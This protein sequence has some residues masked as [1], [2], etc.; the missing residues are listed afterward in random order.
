M[1]ILL[2]P[3]FWI[4][5][6]VM[7]FRFIIKGLDLSPTKTVF[8]LKCYC[9]LMMPLAIEA[10][11]RSM[12]YVSS[13]WS[14]QGEK[15]IFFFLI[16]SILILCF[17]IL[18]LNTKFATLITY[19]IYI[20]IALI[21]FVMVAAF[22]L[23]PFESLNDTFRNEFSEIAPIW[24]FV[25]AVLFGLT[26][27]SKF[28][29]LITPC[30]VM[31]F[32]LM[33]ISSSAFLAVGGLPYSSTNTSFV[34]FEASK[35]IISVWGCIAAALYGLSRCPIQYEKDSDEEVSDEEV[36]GSERQR[37]YNKMLLFSSI[38]G[39]WIVFLYFTQNSGLTTYEDYRKYYNEAL[40]V[41]HG[42]NP[43]A[44]SEYFPA[45][46]VNISE[47]IVLRGYPEYENEIREKSRSVSV[48]LKN[49]TY[50]LQY[51]MEAWFNF[52]RGVPSLGFGADYR[53]SLEE[54]KKR[55][56]KDKKNFNSPDLDSPYDETGGV[57]FRLLYKK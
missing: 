10:L 39:I 1:Q 47:R 12:A 8:F 37:V 49:R 44:L 27:N 29:K 33:L 53:V 15:I 42:L 26:L 54:Y 22:P 40:R 7:F 36:V 21:L 50:S 48:V 3:I 20:F 28:D 11:I 25:T 35:Q 19:R 16:V 56:A 6:S 43:G 5:Y 24:V 34:S 41:Y 4:I 9:I 46:A 18:T 38:L 2:H 14:A 17:C 57:F 23:S 55:L 52:Y 13:T 31:A 45:E 32:A 51:N 30:L